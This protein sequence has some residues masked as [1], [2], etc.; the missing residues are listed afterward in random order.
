M[1][2]NSKKM[3]CHFNST[4][5]ESFTEMNT[6]SVS[7]VR[8]LGL[9]KS[10]YLVHTTLVDLARPPIEQRAVRKISDIALVLNRIIPLLEGFAFQGALLVFRQKL[11]A[12]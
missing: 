11:G 2:V 9:K 1:T 12:G 7:L 6:F 3:E 8:L 4:T 10:K 5:V